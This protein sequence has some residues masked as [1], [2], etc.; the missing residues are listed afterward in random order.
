MVQRIPTL[1]DLWQ[2]RAAFWL[3][4]API[5]GFRGM[6]FLSFWWLRGRLY[7]YYILWEGNR[8]GVGLATSEDGVRFRNHGMVIPYG[9]L[10]AWDE[11]MA[12]F[13]GVWHDGST[14]YIVYEGASFRREWPGDIG[15]ATSS[16][17]FRWTKH[18][19][20]ILVHR[21]SVERGN[22]GTPNLWKVGEQ[23][24]LFYHAYDSRDVRIR[25]V[26]GANLLRLE[27][28]ARRT[29]VDVGGSNAW[30]CGTVGKRS[31]IRQGDWYYMVF[32]GS[33]N[34]PFERAKWSSGVAR[35]RDLVTWE[36]WVHNPVLAQTVSGYGNDGP[37]WVRTAD[38][39]LHIYFRTEPSNTRRATLNWWNGL[40]F[41]AEN[42][43]HRTGRREAEGW[44]ADPAR[45]PADFLCYG[46][47]T[48][49]LPLGKRTALF[50][51]MINGRYRR[52][53]IIVQLDVHDYTTGR[54]L[55]ER[56]LRGSDFR[57][58]GV[59]QEFALDFISPGPNRLEFRTYWHRKAYIRQDWVAVI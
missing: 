35:S 1:D 19:H 43:S 9:S 30:D 5:I 28:A 50:S 59:Y 42:L 57:Q 25:L 10:N 49:R 31:I 6:H 20:P 33:T 54:I 16:D 47:Y 11:R 45:D 55:A 3:D 39:Y 23:W 41:E 13:P 24:F 29:V 14:W 26:S 22:I 27:T 32:E 4:S 40:R 53:D 7:A 46:P 38:G 2:R 48:D 15:L 36:K 18:P 17:G 12:S 52:D 44:A 34:A 21:G 56:T 58:N 8:Q 37:E 51:L